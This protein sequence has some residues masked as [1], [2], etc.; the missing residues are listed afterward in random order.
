MTQAFFKIIFCFGCK[1]LKKCKINPTF[2][3]DII[4]YFCWNILEK[5]NKRTNCNVDKTYACLKY[6]ILYMYDVSRICL[7]SKF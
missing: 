6:K 5:S 2:K 3:F 1:K 7:T 4:N